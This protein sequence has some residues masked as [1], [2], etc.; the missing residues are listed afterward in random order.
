MLQKVL[1]IGLG[2]VE[3]REGIDAGGDRRG[4]GV[5]GVELGD[6]GLCDTRLVWR[7]GK[8]FRA[9]L[10]AAV[11]A[12]GIMHRGVQG[13]AEEDLQDLSVADLLGVV[14]DL[15]GFGVAGVAGADGVVIGGVRLA[16]AVAGQHALDATYVF[17]DALDAPEATAGEHGGL[18]RG[19]RGKVRGGRGDHVL[20]FGAC[21]GGEQGGG[22]EEGG[23]GQAQAE[24][25]QAVHAVAPFWKVRATPFMQ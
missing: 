10:R 24:F 13:Y 21:G 19:G 2:R 25:C 22:G 14:G 15:D 11:G 23:G 9:V 6:V 1:V 3:A 7:G 16:A 4:V 5:G 18:R 17:E 8:D 20:A 12:L